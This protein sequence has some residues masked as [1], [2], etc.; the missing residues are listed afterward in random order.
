L[1]G[2]TEVSRT[3]PLFRFGGHPPATQESA[4][5]WI[6]NLSMSPIRRAAYLAQSPQ[7]Y[8]EHC[9]AG[10]E[11]VYETGH[12]YRAEPQAS[13][14]HLTKYFSLDEVEFAFIDAPEDVI[15]SE[16]E[17]LT[18]IFTNLN[19]HHGETIRKYRAEPLP[20]ML[21]TPCLPDTQ[22]AECTASRALSARSQPNGTVVAD[23]PRFWSEM[24]FFPVDGITRGC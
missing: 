20:S 21:N 24:H 12:V 8:K 3:R 10:L 17:L 9:V 4:F 16:R 1:A 19:A 23:R 11:R 5:Q 2:Y 13:S 6:E 18:D 22:S 14:R 15:Q 7:F